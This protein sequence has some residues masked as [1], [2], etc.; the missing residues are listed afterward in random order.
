[1]SVE[2]ADTRRYAI[3][4][5]P[6]SRSRSQSLLN[7]WIWLNSKAVSSASMHGIKRLM[8]NCDSPRQYL[9]FNCD[10]FLLFIIWRH[11][12]FKLRVFDIW[13]TNF[14]S[15]EESTH[16]P[17]WGLFCYVVVSTG[18]QAVKDT[19]QRRGRLESLKA[20]MGW[21][22]ETDLSVH[23]ESQVWNWHFE[24]RSSTCWPQSRERLP[25]W[26]VGS[27]PQ[28]LVST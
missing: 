23:S 25:Q 20:R 21:D 2:V 17:I 28:T 18:A 12:T 27:M 1:M 14:A 22:M 11:I 10:R 5:H 19:R 13:Q 8:V 4:P 26:Q 15:R 3:W 7:M 6:R 9:N 16:S 24:L